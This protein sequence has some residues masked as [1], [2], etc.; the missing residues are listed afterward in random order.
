MPLTS[1]LKVS[2]S[3]LGNRFDIVPSNRS[4]SPI[5][6]RRS[7]RFE[8]RSSR[9]RAQRRCFRLVREEGAD[10]SR[11]GAHSIRGERRPYARS[12]LSRPKAVL[13]ERT[14]YDP[15]GCCAEDSLA[16][17]S[18]KVDYD[19]SL[20]RVAMA[21]SSTGEEGRLLVQEGPARRDYWL[22]PPR[23]WRVSRTGCDGSCSPPLGARSRLH[24]LHGYYPQ[25][26]HVYLRW[27]HLNEYA[28]QNP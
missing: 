7:Y 12:S 25:H 22:W 8:S 20:E 9:P 15:S 17:S 24:I 18:R 27:R 26:D 6:A 19:G 3:P 1:P 11:C 23:L 21:A 4:M 28:D 13:F 14:R 5:I 16:L 2:R 10:E